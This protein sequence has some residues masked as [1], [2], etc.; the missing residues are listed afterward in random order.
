MLEESDEIN[1]GSAL[2]S[3]AEHAGARLPDAENAGALGLAGLLLRW[4]GATM[5]SRAALIIAALLVLV[6]LILVRIELHQ[7]RVLNEMALREMQEE[8]KRGI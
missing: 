1:P 7:D 5:L 4:A 3:Q 6:L 8:E 2:S